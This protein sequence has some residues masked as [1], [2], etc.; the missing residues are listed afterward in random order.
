MSLA[1]RGASIYLIPAPASI[2]SE[3]SPRDSVVVAVED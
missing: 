1:C 2:K 3:F